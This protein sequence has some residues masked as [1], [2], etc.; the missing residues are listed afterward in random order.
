MN[1][2]TYKGKKVNLYVLENDELKVCLSDLGATLVSFID[3]KTGIDI[4]YGFDS[5]EGYETQHGSYIGAT[6]GRTCN[7][8][9]KG[10]FT[11][12][13]K[14]YQVPV[15]NGPNSLHGGIEGFSFKIFDTEIKDNAI[16][17][18]YFSKDMEEGYPGNLTLTVEYKLCKNSLKFTWSAIS[19]QDTIVSITNHAY[20]NCNGEGTILNHTLKIN[21]DKVALLDNDGMT[22]DQVIDVKGTAFDFTD[23][24]VIYEKLEMG[25]E[26]LLVANGY[27]H[28]YVYENFDVKEMA[29]LKGDTLQLDIIS[30]CPD[31]HVYGGNF[32]DG[33]CKGKYG[34]Y[35]Q[36]KSAMCFECQYYPNSI[37]YEGF[38]KPILKANERRTHFTEFVVTCHKEE[39]EFF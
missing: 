1:F 8:T 32:L 37:N 10:K 36:E 17:F 2:G 18:T 21:T 35:Y 15:N 25:H 9:A 3:K 24:H 30:D 29:T 39:E 33:E 38:I 22:T 7:R 13:G 19:D 23:E 26:N 34:D 14:E 27:D 16:V 11:L 28:N 12:N 5:A 6:V 4:V 20:F 31:M